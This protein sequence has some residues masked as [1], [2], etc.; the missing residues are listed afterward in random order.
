MMEEG[1]IGSGFFDANKDKLLMGHRMG[2]P[3]ISNME[4]ARN[5]RL[6]MGYDNEMINKQPPQP[7]QQRGVPDPFAMAPY[8]DINMPDT[9]LGYGGGLAES[10]L[11]DNEVPQ[12]I[13]K[14]FWFIFHKDNTL[15]FL[16]EPRKSSKLLNFDIT[17]IDLL[18]S[19][20]YYDYTFQ[21]ELQLGILRNV[22]ET[23]LDRAMGFK[24]G[25]TKNERIMI[26]S[27]F[28]EQRQISEDGNQNM[29]REGFFKRLLGRR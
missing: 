25:N 15:T 7:P 10:L 3:E 21:T 8:K 28:H 26:Q 14:R 6:P 2:S 5:T 29:I 9:P 12:E 1:P 19:I 23:K 18:N 11:N 13:R 20:P 17:K 24:G 16:D 22:F 27:Q 4:D